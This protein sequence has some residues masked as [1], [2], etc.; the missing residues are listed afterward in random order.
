MLNEIVDPNLVGQIKPGSL[1]K[2]VEVAEK[3]LADYGADRQGMGDVLWN[4]EYCLL[5][6]E[7]V[8]Q[9]E[10]REDMLEGPTTGTIA[11][12]H[13]EYSRLEKDEQRSGSMERYSSQVFSQLMANEGR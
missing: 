3:C 4:L 5:L 1:K 9:R 8:R 6:Q 10:A 11:M 2:F 13:S 12:V 7:N